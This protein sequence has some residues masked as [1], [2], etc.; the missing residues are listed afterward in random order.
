MYLSPFLPVAVS[1]AAAR[2]PTLRGGS[3]RRGAAVH[4]R[5][6]KYYGKGD[7]KRISADGALGNRGTLCQRLWMSGR[8]WASPKTGT[9]VASS[10]AVSGSVVREGGVTD[11]AEE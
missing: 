7:H 8:N 10:T 2:R 9:G 5:C 3:S 11:G 1:A 4:F 6:L